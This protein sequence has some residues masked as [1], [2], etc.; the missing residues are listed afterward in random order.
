MLPGVAA[1]LTQVTVIVAVPLPPVP[2]V[3]PRSTCEDPSLVTDQANAEPWEALMSLRR[4]CG[5]ISLTGIET[6]RAP[7][8]PVFSSLSVRLKCSDEPENRCEPSASRAYASYT[9]VLFLAWPVTLTVRYSV[10]PVPPTPGALYC[11]TLADTL[12]QVPVDS[13]VFFTGA[14]LAASEESTS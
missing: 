10:V 8:P 9:Q 12:P 7:M 13:A 6:S 4:L 1:C 3:S 5:R 14:P 2:Q 11:W